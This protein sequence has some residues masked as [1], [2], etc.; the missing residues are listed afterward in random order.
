MLSL[1]SHPVEEIPEVRGDL[2]AWNEGEWSTPDA[3]G[4]RI[5]G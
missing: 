1:G 2:G 3:E 4:Q 5:Y